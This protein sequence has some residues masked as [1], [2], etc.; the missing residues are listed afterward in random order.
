MKNFLIFLY[1]V[2]VFKTFYLTPFSLF[3]DLLLQILSLG[4][5]YVVIVKKY[6]KIRFYRNI[7]IGLTLL[8]I[9][10]IFSTYTQLKQDLLSSLIATQQLIKGFSPF[11]I[12]YIIKNKDIDF[13][14]IIKWIINFVWLY[15]IFIAI[16]SVTGWSYTFTS[17]LSGNELLITANKYSKG[18]LFFGIIYYLINYFIW[19]KLKNL[20][21][22]FI[23]LFSTQLYDIQRGDVIFISFLFLIMMYSF[24]N[25]N[26]SKKLFLTTPFILFSII[27]I[28]SFI[29]FSESSE[30]FSQ[31]FLLLSSENYVKISD[32]SIFVRIE[33]ADFA[34]RGFL[35]SP[36]FGKGL[37]RASKQES[38][39][40]NIYFYPADIG[41]IGVIYTFGLTGI[42]IYLSY[43]Y[44][45]IKI[46]L[47]NLRP[48]GLVFFFTAMYIFIY[49]IKD[50]SMMFNPS[51]VIFCILIYRYYEY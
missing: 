9:T 37:M 18:I 32:A 1:I 41:I 22:A 16:T 42:L 10:S 43:G 21:F 4:G 25:R 47:R 49:S 26:G 28:S 48:L 31:M 17:P 39:I 50:G 36:M 12:I 19:A 20:F 30:K 6:Y 35:E 34:I 11:F 15:A 23:I 33:E 40:G 27:I 3:A 29:D 14:R 7:V 38:L 8:I 51:Q 44:S 13:N 5:I 2:C 24:K 45:L 46:K